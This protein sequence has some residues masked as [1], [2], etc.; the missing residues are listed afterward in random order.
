M[1]WRPASSARHWG[2][3]FSSLVAIVHMIHRCL[4]F[5]AHPRLDIADV[6][7]ANEAFLCLFRNKY[8]LQI[9]AMCGYD[10][11][12]IHGSLGLETRKLALTLNC[13]NQPATFAESQ[14]SAAS[15]HSSKS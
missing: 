5:S 15:S 13:F 1:C 10:Q 4:N 2:A 9:K 14:G 6:N 12:A 7:V 3:E 11:L 8:Q